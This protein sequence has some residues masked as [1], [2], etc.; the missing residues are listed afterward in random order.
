[1][2]FEATHVVGGQGAPT[3]PSPDGVAPAGP[4][5]DPWLPV[6]V[7]QPWGAWARIRCANG[8]EAWTDARLLQVSTAGYA[9]APAYAAT[10]A[11]APTPGYAPAPASY[12]G[13][14]GRTGG[15]FRVLGPIGAV[16]AVVATWLPWLTAGGLNVD[17]WDLELWAVLTNGNGTDS[18]IKIA[19]PMLVAG[20]AIMAAFFRPPALVLVL[21]AL[22]AAAPPLVLIARW[23]TNDTFAHLGIGPPAGVVAG[24]LL[25]VA[26]IDAAAARR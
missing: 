14:T 12:G 26:A 1:M 22:C 3:W 5:L 23:A 9:P 4:R 7:I 20:L 19:L 17:G 25:L 15:L 6:Q 8:W 11:Y 10:P 21:C 16:I 18:A 13:P 2:V 24:V